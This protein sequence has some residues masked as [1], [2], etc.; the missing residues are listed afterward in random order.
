MGIDA[1]HH[2]ILLVFIDPDG[3]VHLLGQEPVAAHAGIDLQ[4]DLRH[5]CALGGD[6]AQHHGRLQGAHREDHV[7]VQHGVDLLGLIAD[8]LSI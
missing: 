5:G 1:A 8:M 7:H 2:Q 4:V 6:A 3:L